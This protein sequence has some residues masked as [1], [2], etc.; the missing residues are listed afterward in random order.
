MEAPCLRC[1]A[2]GKCCGEKSRRGDVS[3]EN[4]PK[5]DSQ[6]SCLNQ[7]G[8]AIILPHQNQRRGIIIESVNFKPEFEILDG[9]EIDTGAIMDDAV[10][11]LESHYCAM[12]KDKII[13][14]VR[15]VLLSFGLDA[16]QRESSPAPTLSTAPKGPSRNITPEPPFELHDRLSRNSQFSHATE[17][18]QRRACKRALIL[19]I[20]AKCCRRC[21]SD[22]RSFEIRTLGRYYLV[23]KDK[24]H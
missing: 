19:D 10:R 21:A 24:A 20:Y 23:S 2:L 6:F 14:V 5:E 9:S 15:K 8:T 13:S 3:V 12:D 18:A 16:E 4:R 7:S 22:T 17:E 1:K 11:I